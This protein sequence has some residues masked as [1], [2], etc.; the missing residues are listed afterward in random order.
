M[1]KITTITSAHVTI[2]LIAPEYS[3]HFCS[4]KG[5]LLGLLVFMQ[6]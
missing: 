1:N 3:I 5:A 2:L 4:M 6:T